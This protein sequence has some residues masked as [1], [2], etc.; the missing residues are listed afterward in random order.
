MDEH[1]KMWA[2]IE[3]IWMEGDK[4]PYA[5]MK[6][7]IEELV[8]STASKSEKMGWNKAV[9]ECANVCAKEGR[10][11]CNEWNSRLGVSG[12]LRETCEDCATII[13]RLIKEDK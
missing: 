9:E 11:L 13:R 2:M 3:R 8:A 5:D 7:A 6:K 1:R 4:R 12:L 10:G